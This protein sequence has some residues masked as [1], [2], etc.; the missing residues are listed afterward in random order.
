[1]V[2]FEGIDA[3]GKATQARLLAE[4]L[5]ARVW[6]FP[7]YE[8]E[9]GELIRAHLAGEWEVKGIYPH[10]ALNA[11]VHQA[12]Q[13]ADKA[14]CAV[15]LLSAAAKGSVVLDRYWPSACVYGQAAG[16]DLDYLVRL[17]RWLPQPDLFLL[18][19]APQAFA[20]SPAGRRLQEVSSAVQLHSLG[21]RPSSPPVALL[22]EAE[23]LKRARDE[24]QR[25]SEGYLDLWARMRTEHPVRWV[26][27]DGG[28]PV[29][30]VARQVGEAVARLRTWESS[31][32]SGQGEGY[33]RRAH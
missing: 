7:R 30:E 23:K 10:A 29:E 31:Q 14:A 19:D 17:H 9:A 11:F 5:G 8:S 27:L 20:R 18:L 21:D 32:E 25:L 4:R 12:V 22:R 13:L 3:S 15:E 33:G 28:Q 16:L 1:M 6:G 2:C 24:A 26:V